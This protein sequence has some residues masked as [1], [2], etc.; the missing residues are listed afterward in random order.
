MIIIITIVFI[1]AIIIYYYYYY[2]HHIIIIILLYIYIYI[3][4]ISITII[5]IMPSVCAQG[6]PPEYAA[7]H[8]GT[9]VVGHGPLTKAVSGGRI[10]P[11][12]GHVANCVGSPPLTIY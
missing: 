1:V 4:I 7:A 11:P 12:E 2:R 5:I 3:I 6:Q 10:A 9:Q 8:G